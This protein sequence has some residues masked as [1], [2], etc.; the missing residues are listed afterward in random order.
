MDIG[1]VGLRSRRLAWSV[2]A[3]AL[4]VSA[5]PARAQMSSAADSTSGATCS[6]GGGAD[7]DCRNTV[8]FTAACGG[9]CTSFTSR[10]AWNIN[11]DTGVGSTHDTS[12]TAIHTITFNASA[13]GGYRIDI[14]QSR[15]GSVARS[16][17]ASNCDGQ[18]HIGA[19][20]GN[21]NVAFS[22]NT[23]T[24]SAPAVD[25]NNGGGDAHT[26]LSQGGA[27]QLFRF[28]GGV[29]QSH[30]LSFTWSGSVRS[31]SCEASVR[32]GES[33]GTTAGCSVCGYPGNPSRTQ[34]SDGHFVTVT[35]TSLCGNGAVEAAAGEDCDTGIAGS[36][37]C[38]A[39]CKFLTSSTTCRGAAG[40]CDLAEVCS[41]TSATCPAD[42]K[43]S[44]GTACTADTNPCTLDQC[45]GTNVTCQHPAGNA[46]AVCRASAGAC[47]QQETC[48]GSSTTCP[49]DAKVAAATVC[50][51]TA[52][53]CDVAESCDGVSNTCP[54][55]LLQPPTTVCRPAAGV[56][57]AAEN[58]TGSS[59]ACP[60]DGKSTAVCRPSAGV[61]DVAESCDGVSND[62]PGDGFEPDTTV[63]RP[64]AG[65]CDPAENCT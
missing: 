2:A 39:N 37:C 26:D 11:A 43:K 35:L 9:S 59:A 41:G 44:A 49:A 61:C 1:G 48:S 54:T 7:G 5:A 57:D 55:D 6:G 64:S 45:D 29:T 34:S 17:D 58:C 13:V 25:I 50:R 40:E 31:N 32:L 23:L 65:V 33:S 14:S 28:S 52:G 3:M 4:L 19:V 30:S 24:S 22:S 60:P 53:V 36:V 16:S 42:V 27:A 10:Y 62:C 51:P 38:G 18:A 15:V 21:S 56:C 63:C 20:T 12:G 8:A 47:D 46:G